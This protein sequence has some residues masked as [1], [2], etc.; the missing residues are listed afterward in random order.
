[1]AGYPRQEKSILN[2]AAPPS[3]SDSARRL[4]VLEPVAGAARPE[5]TIRLTSRG[6]GSKVRL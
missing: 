5:L 3:A 4:T 1:M 2:A 6:A